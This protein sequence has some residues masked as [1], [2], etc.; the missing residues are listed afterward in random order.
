MLPQPAAAVAAAKNRLS[1]RQRPQVAGFQRAVV[2]RGPAVALVIAFAT[3]AIPSASAEAS[4]GA[5]P[6]APLLE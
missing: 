1:R 6:S 4:A 5:L 3:E 2:I